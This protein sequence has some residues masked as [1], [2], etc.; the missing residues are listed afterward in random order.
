MQD[1]DL[2]QLRA[3][4]SAALSSANKSARA[5]SLDAGMGPDTLGKF[6]NGHT[7]S[8]RADNLARVLRALD[9][10]QDAI[11]GGPRII[12]GNI[13]DTAEFG[14]P[15]GGIVEAGLFRPNDSHDQE[16][17]NRK[18][19]LPADPRYPA[20]S[21]YAFRV[22]GDSMTRAHIWEG[23]HVLAVDVHAWERI[24]GEVGD[25]KLVVV[26]RWRHG[27]SE[28]ELTVKRLRLF[29]DR[30]ELQPETENPRW[31]PIVFP[32]PLRQDEDG[33]AQ[34]IAVVLSATWILT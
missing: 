21:Q 34:I 20:I 4:I 12:M 22:V 29:R 5:V 32:L 17:E 9:I 24:H 10:P 11:V 25:G 14:V 18:V 1:I 28:R 13:S 8:L 2:Q 16:A 26:A 7:Q 31:Q 30:M 33:E 27:D 19:P 3:T 6:L 15:F 23:M